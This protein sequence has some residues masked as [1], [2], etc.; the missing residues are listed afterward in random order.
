MV[1]KRVELLVLYM[2]ARFVRGAIPHNQ[3]VKRSVDASFPVDWDIMDRLKD[4]TLEP[5]QLC[6]WYLNCDRVTQTRIRDHIVHR[7]CQLSDQEIHAFTLVCG[8][9]EDP[10]ISLGKRMLT[11]VCR[12]VLQCRFASSSILQEAKEM[13]RAIDQPEGAPDRFMPRAADHRR[14]TGS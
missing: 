11:K 8:L 2:G 1:D 14:R 13:L 4:P 6:D 10:R 9:L 7:A 12:A 3:V 5:A